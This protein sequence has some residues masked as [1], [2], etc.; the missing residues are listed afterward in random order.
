MNNFRASRFTFHD[1]GVMMS[2][3][4]VLAK[5]IA[6]AKSSNRIATLVEGV[7]RNWLLYVL[8]LPTFLF[9]IAFYYYPMA[10]G[11]YHSFTYWDIKRTVWICFLNYQR[12]F[13]D[14][15][16]LA[17]WRN[18]IVILVSQLVIVMTTPLLGA[19]LVAH[20]RPGLA[21][22]GWRMMFVMPIVV[23]ATVV[24][25]VWRWFYGGDGG[26]NTL[27]RALGL[28]ALTH[29]WLGEHATA[30]WAIIGTG[31]PWVAGLNFLIYLAALQ[32]I[33]EELLDAARV[34]GAS[35]FRRFFQIELPLIR[36][37]M[38]VLVVLTF[39]YYLRSFDAPLIMTNGGP[40]MSGTLVPG[41]Q[42]YRAVRDDLDLGYGSAIGTVL[43]VVTLG[44]MLINQLINR[45]QKSE[46]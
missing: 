12:M 1:D 41:L 8:I 29:L 9:A 37:Q 4:L 19:A 16:A 17:A 11:I 31:F 30:L 39:I 20:L 13:D 43:F 7:R 2:Q 21:Q 40:G 22:Y 33:P 32:S 5:P 14:P 26:L 27:L 6:R 24:V 42:M 46:T 23:P 34:D 44:L 38:M 45:R 28:G 3:D 35:A 18:M 15:V 25:F 36:N 10:S